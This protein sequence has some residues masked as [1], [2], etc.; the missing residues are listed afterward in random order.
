VQQR[1]QT[2]S[3]TCNSGKRYFDSKL[4][5]DHSAFMDAAFDRHNR[6]KRARIE[7]TNSMATDVQSEYRHMQES[8]ASTSKNL[9]GFAG[10]VSSEVG[11]LEITYTDRNLIDVFL[12]QTAGLANVTTT[13]QK[14]ASTDISSI[15][16]ATRSLADQGTKEDAPT[17]LTPRKR[18][19]QYVDHWELTQSRDVVL[20]TWRQRGA[21]KAGSDAFMDENLPFLMD[22][23]LP[24]QSEN[25]EDEEDEEDVKA[26]M[27]DAVV[28]SLEQRQLDE[29]DILATESLV[30]VSLASSPLSPSV[31]LPVAQPPIK[32]TSIATK[33]GL[34]TRGALTDRPTNII[35]HPASRRVR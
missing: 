12:L 23:N 16:Q 29:P 20:K 24:V 22:E 26:M 28:S 25:T 31:P 33:S 7:A 19:W 6:S 10:R 32:K 9:E 34:P 3:S 4:D 21:T 13:Y 27:V 17:G 35:A 14:A 15:Q 1:S 8:I 11:H 18:V 30:A 2:L 5:D